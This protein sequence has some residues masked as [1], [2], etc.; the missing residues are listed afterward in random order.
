LTR[1]QVLPHPFTQASAFCFAAW[2]HHYRRDPAAVERYAA[3]ALTVATEHGLGQWV[4]VAIMLRGW[5]IAAQGRARDGIDDLRRGLEVMKRSGAALNRPHFL[6]ML[7]EA[8]LH[9]T[10]PEEGLEVLDE[11][12]AIAEANQDRC[13]MPELCRLRGVL[14][15]AASNSVD[16]AAASFREAIDLARRQDAKLLELRAASSLARLGAARGQSGDAYSIAPIY[17]WFTEGFDTSDLREAQALMSGAATS[18]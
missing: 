1:A 9:D 15:L 2:A 14:T 17:T 10:R 18:S 16:A 8:Y 6:S 7:A 4:P 13:W 3:A 5:S 12:R 11:A